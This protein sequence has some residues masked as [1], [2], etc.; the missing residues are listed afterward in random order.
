MSAR[1]FLT[2]LPW[3]GRCFLLKSDQTWVAQDVLPAWLLFYQ[4]THLFLSQKS[5]QLTP[6]WHEFALAAATPQTCVT[7][8]CSSAF[9]FSFPVLFWKVSLIFGCFPFPHLSSL[10]PDCFHQ[11]PLTLQSVYS[12]SVCLSVLSFVLSLH[13]S[14][15]SKSSSVFASFERLFL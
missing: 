15:L 9:C 12:L 13:A 14:F 6:W 8:P 1:D 4:N 3:N 7:P 11:F 5:F 10:I 2:C